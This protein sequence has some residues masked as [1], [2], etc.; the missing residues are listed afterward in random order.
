VLLIFGLYL[1]L[2][3]F[4]VFRFKQ[5][6]LTLCIAAINLALL[7]LITALQIASIKIAVQPDAKNQ[8]VTQIT[9]TFH[10]FKVLFVF[11]ALALNIY[12]WG[13]FII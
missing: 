11:Q 9:Q 12:R 4:Q 8:T 6:S 3:V 13:L 10:S 2:R 5:F 1:Q 7:C